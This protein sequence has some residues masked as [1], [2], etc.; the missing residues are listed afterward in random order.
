MEVASAAAT[1]LVST[2]VALGDM[3]VYL[4]ENPKQNRGKG[5][6]NGEVEAEVLALHQHI[7]PKSGSP[8]SPDSTNY[9]DFPQSYSLRT[10][11]LPNLLC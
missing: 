5:R 7:H 1:V 11:K 3:Y 8:G 10:R 9:F 2:V 6:V 4:L